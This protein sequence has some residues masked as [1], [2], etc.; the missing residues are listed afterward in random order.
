MAGRR[1]QTAHSFEEVLGLERNTSGTGLW[2]GHEACCASHHP[3]VVR[4]AELLGQR[5]GAVSLADAVVSRGEDRGL[6]V[7]CRFRE[8]V[9]VFLLP[10]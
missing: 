10:V 8:S 6:N 3:V 4:I 7:M 2:G 1:A 9:K 5:G